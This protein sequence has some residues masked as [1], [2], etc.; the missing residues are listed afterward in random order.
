MKISSNWNAVVNETP[1]SAKAVGD[2]EASKEE[3]LA[4]PK[5][6]VNVLVELV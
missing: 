6:R 4:E 2:R 3:A 5:L 1:H